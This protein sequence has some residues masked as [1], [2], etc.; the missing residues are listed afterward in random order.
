MII[1]SLGD[2][3]KITIDTTKDSHSEI[4]KAITMLA[5]LIGESNVYTNSPSSNS[6]DMFSNSSSATESSSNESSGEMFGMFSEN[7][8]T[9]IV[10]SDSSEKEEDIPKIVEY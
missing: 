6:G 8:Q 9:E 5:S 4:K 1:C 10:D 2:T 3:I 7:A